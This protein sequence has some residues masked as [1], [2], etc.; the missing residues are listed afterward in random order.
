MVK[1]EAIIPI[2]I[3]IC[4]FLQII[5]TIAIIQEDG[6]PTTIIT[7]IVTNSTMVEEKELIV[8]ISLI[9]ISNIFKEEE[10]INTP[11]NQLISH[12][13]SP[14]T[15]LARIHPQIITATTINN[16]RGTR[17]TWADRPLFQRK[18]SLFPC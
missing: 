4:E 5:I 11:Q 10:T 15:M 6:G 1:M 16:N 8:D 2:I 18:C 9:I 3:I 12:K 13:T 17:I 7:L 14:K